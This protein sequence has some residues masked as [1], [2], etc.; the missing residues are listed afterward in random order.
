MATFHKIKQGEYLSKVAAKYGFADYRVIWDHPDNAELKQRRQNPNVLYPGDRLFIPDKGLREE[1]CAT[2]QRHRFR[3]QGQTLMLRIVIKDAEDQPVANTQCEL[4][5]ELTAYQLTTDS[6][7][8][9]EQRIPVT[10]KSGKLTIL[11]MKIPLQ[12]GKLDPVEEVTGWQARLNNLGYKAGPI[13]SAEE[14]Q[15][16]SAIEEFQCDYGLEVDGDCGPNTQAKL[17]EVHGC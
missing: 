9:V 1:S 16:R 17:K 3:F 8:R 4:L 15:I 11:D 12:I 13:G 2:D 5:V 10:A 14:E 6:D 7:G